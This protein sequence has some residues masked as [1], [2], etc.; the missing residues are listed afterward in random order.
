[1]CKQNFAGSLSKIYS[2]VH[3]FQATGS[4]NN[5]NKTENPRSVRKLTAICPDNVDVVRDSVGGS[6]KKSLRR[7]SQ[8]LGPSRKLYDRPNQFLPLSS[9]LT[10]LKWYDCFLRIRVNMTWSNMSHHINGLQLF[11]NKVEY[12]FATRSIWRI[13]LGQAYIGTRMGSNQLI[14]RIWFLRLTFLPGK[15][16]K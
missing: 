10:F 1:M 9:G 13:Q 7:S 15:E 6:S 2:W 16:P 5:L 3:K 12:V 8:E 4:V 11:W 14:D